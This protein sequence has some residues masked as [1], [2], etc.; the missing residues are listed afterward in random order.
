MAASMKMA[1]S[2][3]GCSTMYSGRSL[4]MFQM[5]LLPPS[6]ITLMMESASAS[7]MSVNFYQTTRRYSPED[8]HL[9]N[10]SCLILANNLKT[11]ESR[12]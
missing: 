4:P 8:S 9:L 5:Y 2:L 11:S 12:D 6:L 7:E 3:L 10:F 1:S